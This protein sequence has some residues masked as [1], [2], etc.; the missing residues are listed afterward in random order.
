MEF[1]FVCNEVDTYTR[2]LIVYIWSSLEI[3]Q[4]RNREQVPES[5]TGPAMC[6]TKLHI[7][8]SNN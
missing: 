7:N 6:S 5:A 3:I 4:T 2:I 8:V 1:E